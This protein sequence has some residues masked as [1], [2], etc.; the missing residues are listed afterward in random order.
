MTFKVG[1]ITSSMVQIPFVVT[2][3]IFNMVVIISSVVKI[4]LLS[5]K[6]AVITLA[7]INL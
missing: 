5:F 7:K 2:Q 3:I 6:V 4:T 1:V